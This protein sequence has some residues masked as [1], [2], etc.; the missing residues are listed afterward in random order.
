MDVTETKI[1]I[2]EDDTD[3]RELVR[4]YLC[5]EKFQVFEAKNGAE[6]LQLQQ[7]VQPDLLLLDILLPDMDGYEVCKEIRLTSNVPVIFMSCKMDAQD[8]ITGL[9]IG[10][11][12]YVTKPFD[13][14]V[15]IYRV[16]AK[17]RRYHSHHQPPQPISQ[18]PDR[19]QTS[20]LQEMIEPLTKREMEIL[21]L[22]EIGFTNQEIAAHFHISVG[23]VKGYNNQLFSKLRVRNRTQAILQAR[24]MGILEAATKKMGKQISKT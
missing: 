10:A 7:T 21:S 15:L 14:E 13:P 20:L 18:G 16:K 6:A 9:Q 2:V 8:I 1:L 22:I 23:T 4:L 3:I 11:D 19:E 12:D 17:L 24:Q 5:R